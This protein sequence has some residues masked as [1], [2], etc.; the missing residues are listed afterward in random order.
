[1]LTERISTPVQGARA[2][3]TVPA[4]LFPNGKIIH[5]KSRP[6]YSGERNGPFLTQIPKVNAIDH[7]NQSFSTRPNLNPMHTTSTK[8][9]R[10]NARHHVKPV[11]YHTKSKLFQV[12]Y[13]VSTQNRI[14]RPETPQTG[15]AQHGTDTTTPPRRVTLRLQHSTYTRFI[16]QNHNKIQVFGKTMYHILKTPCRRRNDDA[17]PLPPVHPKN[18]DGPKAI[19]TV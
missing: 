4:V 10:E 2:V 11:L 18:A 1:M 13:H 12:P 3:A 15:H 14:R 17:I 8:K 5:L 19:S 9:K 6:S 7:S 16:K